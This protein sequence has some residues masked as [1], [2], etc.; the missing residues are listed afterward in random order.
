MPKRINAIDCYSY[1]VEAWIG[2]EPMNSGFADHCLT[3]WLPR[4]QITN[5]LLYQIT[6]E[7]FDGSTCCEA[8]SA[9]FLLK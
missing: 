1:I 3:T 8:T 5:K 6:L 9:P 2:I 7:K 4:H